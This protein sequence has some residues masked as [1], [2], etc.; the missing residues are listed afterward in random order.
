MEEAC[1]SLALLS[2]EKLMRPGKV[3]GVWQAILVGDK[4]YP[5]DNKSPK[6]QERFCTFRKPAPV[7]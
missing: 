2:T 3:R 5:W 4:K 6:K 1:E 7:A